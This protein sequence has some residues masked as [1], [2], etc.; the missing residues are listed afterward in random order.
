MQSGIWTVP[1]ERMKAKIEHTVPLS[2][3]A[4][5]IVEKRASRP[6]LFP[7]N[8]SG[9]TLSENA[10]SAVLKRMGVGH[11]TVQ[12]FRSTFKDWAGETT[13]FPDDLSEAAL[14]HRIRDKAKAACKRGTM[15][16]KRRSMMQ[17]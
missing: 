1:G 7:N 10:M 8:L 15:L 12:G 16:E 9:E 17:A 11:V 4:L 5:A 13:D 6:L 2:K 3:P 14:A